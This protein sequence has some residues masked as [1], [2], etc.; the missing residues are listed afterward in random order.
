MMV[1][2]R[3]NAFKMMANSCAPAFDEQVEIA[4]RLYGRNITFSWGNKEVDRLLSG[5]DIY[6][7]EIVSRVRDLLAER[8][9][10]YAYLFS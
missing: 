2:N 5:A 8:R 1:K 10:K 9:R 4:E 7:D 6:S 3:K